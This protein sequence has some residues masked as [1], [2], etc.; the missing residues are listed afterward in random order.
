MI[1]KLKLQLNDVEINK[2]AKYLKLAQGNLEKAV[3][4]RKKDDGIS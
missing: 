4:M 1:K 3:E 2:C